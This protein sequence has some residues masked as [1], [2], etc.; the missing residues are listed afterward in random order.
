MSGLLE[1]EEKQAS[2]ARSIGELGDVLDISRRSSSH[3]RRQVMSK[4]ILDVSDHAGE[5]NIKL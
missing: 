3:S 5:T 4:V 2:N 1:T